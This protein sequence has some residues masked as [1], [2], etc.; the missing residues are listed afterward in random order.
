MTK[1]WPTLEGLGFAAAFG[2]G[3][4]AGC[5]GAGA[6]VAG[7]GV[8]DEATGAEATGASGAAAGVGAA[9]RALETVGCVLGAAASHAGAADRPAPPASTAAVANTETTASVASWMRVMPGRR[10]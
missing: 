5:A 7:I 10:R 2:L 9:G 8:G 1:M 3:S 6:D 4:V